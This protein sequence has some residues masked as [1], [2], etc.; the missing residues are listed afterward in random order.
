MSEPSGCSAGFQVILTRP[1]ME[2]AL[3]QGVIIPLSEPLA[4]LRESPPQGG[5]RKGAARGQSVW[6]LRNTCRALPQKH[7][8][9]TEYWHEKQKWLSGII[10][11][12]LSSC[13][14][15]RQCMVMRASRC[16][17]CSRLIIHR[18][19]PWSLLQKR[20]TD[21]VNTHLRR[22][23]DSDTLL[24]GLSTCFMTGTIRGDISFFM[25]DTYNHENTSFLPWTTL[26]YAGVI[27]VWNLCW[28]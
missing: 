10:K 22:I 5:H 8:N 19:A 11:H 7:I 25:C 6:R 14:R 1:R 13:C 9:L 12:S 20:V 23:Y 26:A 15:K 27:E 28:I 16:A 21:A 3:G 2:P 18:I 24:G 17:A 4:T